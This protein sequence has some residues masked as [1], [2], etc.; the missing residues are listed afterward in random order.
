M[1]VY[2]HK[3]V[4]IYFR[5]LPPRWGGGDCHTKVSWQVS[6]SDDKTERK[7]TISFFFLFWGQGFLKL[8]VQALPTALTWIVLINAIFHLHRKSKSVLLMLASLGGRGVQTQNRG[9]LCGDVLMRV[10]DQRSGWTSS[11]PLRLL[12]LPSPGICETTDGGLGMQAVC[13]N[14]SGQSWFYPVSF[15]PW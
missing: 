2:L 5:P 1:Y 6:W 10:K 14:S 9:S 4:Y 15:L 3:A 12:L 13:N 8:T 7:T 11:Y